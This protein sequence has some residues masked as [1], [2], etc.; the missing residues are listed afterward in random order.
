MVEA[1]VHLCL[2][3]VVGAVGE[4]AGLLAVAVGA[5][6]PGCL[7][8]A[9]LAG[10]PPAGLPARRG[11]WA[12]E[13]VAVGLL[14]LELALPQVGDLSPART[15]TGRR[16][17]CQLLGLGGLISASPLYACAWALSRCLPTRTY[18]SLAHNPNPSLPPN[19]PGQW[20]LLAPPP[21]L[22]PPPYLSQLEAPAYLGWGN[23]W[24]LPPES[25]H[26]C[27]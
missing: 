20:Y 22:V 1:Q 19:S 3:A 8:G 24:A 17:K 2:E 14:L 4:A 9:G 12:V 13:V 16:L 5:G 7:G 15:R 11:G 23:R 6:V 27:R 25:G 21:D 18:L 10:V 26:H